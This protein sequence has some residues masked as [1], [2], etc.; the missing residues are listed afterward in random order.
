MSIIKSNSALI[1]F[2]QGY[3]D[4]LDEFIFLNFLQSLSFDIKTNRIDS[5]HIGQS[6]SLVNQ[7]VEPEISLNINF[8]QRKDFL[9][10]SLFG[11]ILSPNSIEKQSFFK[12][13]I[14]NNFFNKNAFI[15]FNE[16]QGYDLIYSKLNNSISSVSMGNLYLNTYSVS[17]KINQLPTVSIDF[18][19]N[20]IKIDK[21]TNDLKL[22]NW[23]N[24]ELQLDNSALENLKLDTNNAEFLVYVMNGLYASTNFNSNSYSPGISIDSL[25]NG[26][27][28]SLDVSI[29]LNRNKLYFFNQTNTV[30]ERNVILPIK[31]S[32][33]I[34][35]ISFNLN[36]GNIKEFFER[37]S[38][39][40]IVLD[41]L[42]ELKQT[43]ST[44]IYEN[45]I[46]ESFSYSI[47]LNGFLEYSLDC[48]FQ[49]TDIDGL[50][51]ISEGNPSLHAQKI[52]SSDLK[53]LKAGNS[54][55]YSKI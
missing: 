18:L 8:L 26:I 11:L 30:S 36:I 37:N 47:N 6:K 22:K 51:I 45:L 23:D 46:V 9:N 21:I 14:Q 32:L 28:Q 50:K 15:L 24:S 53:D 54:F 48:S 38:S 19:C 2:D 25:L 3:V 20:N 13:I 16:V 40:Y 1:A 34:S 52:Q 49:I 43:S 55:L 33:K 41:I 5:K 29:N 39:F 12:K 44:V 27:I 17:Y 10:E 42:D 4:K 35:G 7:F 31:G